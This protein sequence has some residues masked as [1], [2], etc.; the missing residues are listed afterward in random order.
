MFRNIQVAHPIFTEESAGGSSAIFAQLEFKFHGLFEAIVGHE[1]ATKGLPEGSYRHNIHF[2]CEGAARWIYGTQVVDLKPGYAYWAPGNTPLMRQCEQFYR[3]YFLVL[4]CE[5][6]G[7]IDFMVNWP[8]RRPICLGPWNEAEWREEWV[9]RP[10]SLNTQMRLQGQI[11]KWVAEQ[12]ENLDEIIAQHTRRYLRYAR[13]F[14]MMET[15]L[16]ADLQVQELAQAYGTSLRAFSLSFTRDLGL[17]PKAYLNQRLNQCACRLL[18]G[19]D[20]P[21]KKIARELQFA[22][23]HYFTRFFAKMNGIPPHKYRQL[24]LTSAA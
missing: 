8:Q 4:S 10:H 11:Y 9:Q 22:D 2:V 12:F 7:G 14:E 16:G 6:G 1:W 17:S 24:F 20:W 15:R 5:L 19:H 23:E 3:H 18:V 21:V 13:V